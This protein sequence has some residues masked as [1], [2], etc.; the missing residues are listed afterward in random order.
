MQRFLGDISLD[1][2]RIFEAAARLEG[3]TAA[4]DEL[5]TSQ[6]AVSQQIKRLERQLEVRLFDRVHRGLR[7]TEA[8]EILLV[9]TQD[10]LLKLDGGIAAV[11]SR[12]QQEVLQVATDHAF[13]AYWLMPRL[14]RFHAENPDID[15]SLLTRERGLGT[16][17]HS[18]DMLIGFGDGRSKHGEAHFLFHEEVFPVCS[19]VL[20]QRYDTRDLRHLPLLHLRSER[21]ARWFEWS[22]LFQALDIP[23]KVPPGGLHFDNYTLVIQAA[24]AAQGVA[25]GW[26]YLMD[27]LIAQGV[28]TRLGEAGGWSARG[29]YLIVPERKRR[30]HLM[31]RF[32]DWLKA[33][34][35]QSKALPIAR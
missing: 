9:A 6:P 17:S 23:G 2:L 35:R 20:L 31:E 4:A 12:T 33:E 14:P 27:D 5:G 19:P 7:L 13:A 22:E 10:G 26:R 32:V 15:V 30:S 16:I 29:Y 28:L 8:G 11:R 25:I 3:F 21:R 34:L 24:I 1:A 18:V